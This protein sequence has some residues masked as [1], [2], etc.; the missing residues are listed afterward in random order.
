MVP[1]DQEIETPNFNNNLELNITEVAENTE[2]QGPHLTPKTDPTSPPKPNALKP[3][4][5]ATQDPSGPPSPP[6]KRPKMDR[7]RRPSHYPREGVLSQNEGSKLKNKV[8][9]LVKNTK[10]EK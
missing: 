9:T 8:F 5:T 6:S 1:T 10:V 3:N 7:E 4:S 2:V